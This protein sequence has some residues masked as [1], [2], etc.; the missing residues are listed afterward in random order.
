M[1]VKKESSAEK[2]V[3]ITD[4]N[5]ITEPDSDQT[6]LTSEQK[7]IQQLEQEIVKLKTRKKKAEKR[8]DREQALKPYQAELIKL[9]QYL[10]ET[11][12]RMIILFEGRDASGKG[13]TIRRVTRYMNE[14]HYRNVALGKPTAEQ[15]TQWYFQRYVEQLPHGGEM[16]LFDRSWYNRAMVEPVLG[17]CTQEEHKNF[18]KGVV[19]F[20]KD[21]VRQGTIFVKLY[22]SVTKAEQARRF[23]RRKTD[24]LRQWKLSEVDI[25]AQDHWDEF[26]NAKYEMLKRSHASAAPWIIVRS[27]NKHAARMNV[28]K[29]IL[30]S[31]PYSNANPD[32]DFIP[33]PDIVVS[34][35]RE[36]ESME[37]DRLT[38]GKFKA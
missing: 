4:N 24:P 37:G 7:K 32:L 36:I 8:Y 3:T 27:N 19:G 14:K 22:F 10:E 38:K 17:F 26:T 33:D 29:V 15:R 35:A 34:G 30:N 23:E 16:V 21:L 31:V 9:Q 25:Q 6:D 13:G 28:L 11:Q 20:E 5:V 12:K 2:V 1:T 18:M